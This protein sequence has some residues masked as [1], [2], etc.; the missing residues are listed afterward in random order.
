M[1]NEH[2][3]K[4][5]RAPII[6]Q[7]VHTFYAH[8]KRHE[9]KVDYQGMMEIIESRQWLIKLLALDGKYSKAS[10]FF[11]FAC[12]QI[13]TFPGGIKDYDVVA[14]S[15]HFCPQKGFWIVQAPAD[16]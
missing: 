10:Q 4:V 1:L 5:L 7:L 9:N 8:W 12:N 15:W 13:F 14:S 16:T 3:F 11:L 6:S 2:D